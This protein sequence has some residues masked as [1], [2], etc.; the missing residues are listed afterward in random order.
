MAL[1]DAG[2]R[3][4]DAQVARLVDTLRGLGCGRTVSWPSPPITARNSSTMA[5]ATIPLRGSLKNWY[6]F[7][8][9][10]VRPDCLLEL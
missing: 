10:C 9:C 6:A 2:I 3:W 7:L 1:Y 8:F 4:V 5:A